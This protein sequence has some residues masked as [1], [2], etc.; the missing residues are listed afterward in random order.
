M[1]FLVCCQCFQLVCV[2][3]SIEFLFV[4]SYIYIDIYRLVNALVIFD[5]IARITIPKLCKGEDILSHL[6]RCTVQ[7][8]IRSPQ[9]QEKDQVSHEFAAKKVAPPKTVSKDLL[10][11]YI[12]YSI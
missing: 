8:Y 1:A 6:L 12:V 11:S 7:L 5:G 4:Y 3:G 9:F 10:F 2:F